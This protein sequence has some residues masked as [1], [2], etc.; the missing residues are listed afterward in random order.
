M[1]RSAQLIFLRNDFNVLFC[2]VNVHLESLDCPDVR[3]AQLKAINAYLSPISN[4]VIIN[5][6]FNFCRYH[7]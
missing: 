6:D 1:N 2:I 7:E 5:G 3:A 4:N